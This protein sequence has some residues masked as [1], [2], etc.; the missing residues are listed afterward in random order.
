MKEKEKDIF[1]KI[2]A[3][4][5]LNIFEGFYQKYKRCSCIYFLEE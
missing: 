2:M 5:G 4:P 3:L 1:D